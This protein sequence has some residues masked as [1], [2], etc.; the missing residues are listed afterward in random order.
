MNTETRVRGVHSSRPGGYTHNDAE[1]GL[2]HDQGLQGDAPGEID[3]EAGGGQ[4]KDRLRNPAGHWIDFCKRR[5][6]RSR[7][8]RLKST[9]SAR[10]VTLG[11]PWRRRN[12]SRGAAE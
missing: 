7:V 9:I 10:I 6:K 8:W 3:I 11:A 2:R 12:A 4:R 5:E 1:D